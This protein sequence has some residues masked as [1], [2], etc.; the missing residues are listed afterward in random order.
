MG[1]V[2]TP[3]S[4]LD[5]R[6]ICMRQSRVFPQGLMFQ[7]DPPSPPRGYMADLVALLEPMM[8]FTCTV[9]IADGYGALINGSWNGLV[10]E[11]SLKWLFSVTEGICLLYTSPSPR[12]KRQSRMP[13]SA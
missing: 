6:G 10:N 9:S 1:L 2:E 7:Y 13:S 11:A 8:N 4:F 3:V 5:M 12:D